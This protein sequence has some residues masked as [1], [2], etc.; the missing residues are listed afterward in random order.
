MAYKRKD[1]FFF[2]VMSTAGQ[3]LL[4]FMSSSFQDADLWSRL[5]GTFLVIIAEIKESLANYCIALKTLRNKKT[6]CQL[7][8]YCPKQFTWSHLSSNM[9]GVDYS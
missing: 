6:L 7:K 4:C 9:M 1:F 5:Y 8:L 2:H 3:L